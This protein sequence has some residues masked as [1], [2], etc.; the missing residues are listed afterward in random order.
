MHPQIRRVRRIEGGAGLVSVCVTQARIIRLK[1]IA[2]RGPEAGCI[3]RRGGRDRGFQVA[4]SGG[5][6]EEGPE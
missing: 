1:W 2:R 4:G 3:G 6:P 5:A